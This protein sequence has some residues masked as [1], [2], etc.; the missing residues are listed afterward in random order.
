MNEPVYTKIEDTFQD[1]CFE[2]LIES[3]S[4]R[5]KTVILDM[6]DDELGLPLVVKP[7]IWEKYGVV[8]SPNENDFHASLYDQF[9]RK[10]YLSPKQ[11]NALR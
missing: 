8:C 11:I 6:I 5:H 10:G 9:E 3:N 1:K 2:E 4:P 7:T